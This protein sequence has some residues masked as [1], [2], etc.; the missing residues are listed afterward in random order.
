MLIVAPLEIYSLPVL[1]LLWNNFQYFPIKFY[2]DVVDLLFK[3]NWL[4]E[5]KQEIIFPIVSLRVK[6]RQKWFIG[7]LSGLGTMRE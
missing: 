4:K 3:I 2:C 5:V 7:L 1:K 6:A